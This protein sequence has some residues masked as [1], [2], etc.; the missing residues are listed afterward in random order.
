MTCCFIFW[1]QNCEFYDQYF[2]LSLSFICLGLSVLDNSYSKHAHQTQEIS[3]YLNLWIFCVKTK[4]KRTKTNTIVISWNT[5]K[6]TGIHNWFTQ[7]W[8]S[9]STSTFENNYSALFILIPNGYYTWYIT[10]IMYAI[11]FLSTS[12]IKVHTS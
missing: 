4:N 6:N 9:F 10:F 5:W 3:S 1:G 7:I 11:S 8:K 12:V 2:E